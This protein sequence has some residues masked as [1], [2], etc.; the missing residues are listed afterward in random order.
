MWGDE[1]GNHDADSDTRS[2]FAQKCEIGVS[3]A[4]V[5]KR[6]HNCRRQDRGERRAD[7]DMGCLIRRRATREKTI[8]YDGNDDNAAAD[9]DQPGEQPGSGAGD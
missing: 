3:G 7:R 9:P 1:L 8:V 2:P 5:A 4:P 6:R